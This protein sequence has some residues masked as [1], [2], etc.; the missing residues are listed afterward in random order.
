MDLAINH[1]LYVN[2][3]EIASLF[4]H[5]GEHELHNTEK[6]LMDIEEQVFEVRIY[7]ALTVNS[8][9]VGG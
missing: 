8:G 7:S 9:V 1:L 2:C 5:S 6:I 4:D 3:P